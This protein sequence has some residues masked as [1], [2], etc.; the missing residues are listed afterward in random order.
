MPY[1][2][3]CKEYTNHEEYGRCPKCKEGVNEDEW[4]E[5]SDD[6]IENDNWLSGLNKVVTIKEKNYDN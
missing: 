1:S 4:I 2:P 6:D 5:E 3:C